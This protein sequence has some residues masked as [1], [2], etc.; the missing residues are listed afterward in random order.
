M[1]WLEVVEIKYLKVQ[2]KKRS[3]LKKFADFAQIK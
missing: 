3:L 2:E 1:K